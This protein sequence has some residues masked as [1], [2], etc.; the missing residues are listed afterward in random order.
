MSEVSLPCPIAYGCSHFVPVSQI[1]FRAMSLSR[2]AMTAVGVHVGMWDAEEAVR[3]EAEFAIIVDSEAVY[4][5]DVKLAF[6]RLAALDAELHDDF[7]GLGL[8]GFGH[9]AT[10]ANE[11]L[12]AHARSRVLSGGLTVRWC[13][14]DRLKWN[15][16]ITL[17]DVGRCGVDPC[18]Y[19]R[20][21]ALRTFDEAEM[22]TALGY[23]FDNYHRSELVGLEGVFRRRLTCAGACVQGRIN[24]L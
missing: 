3:G 24:C 1:V 17:R 15:H 9:V 7:G 19:R 6:A 21:D 22:V 4:N 11:L 18:E 16:F 2:I 10:L 23:I 12:A 20:F 13:L 8:W 5:R 14:F